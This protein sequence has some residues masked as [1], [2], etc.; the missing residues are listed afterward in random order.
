MKQANT[1][2]SSRQIARITGFFYLLIIMGGLYGSLFVREALIDP[3][4]ELTTLNNIIENE[5]QYRIG[6]LS[7]LVM[8]ISDVMVSVL[9][10]ILLSPVS[11]IA[12]TFAAA[13][14]L[15]QS[16]ILGANLTNLFKPV[17]LISVNSERGAD[18][19]S[20]P[21]HDIMIS[22]QAFEY[23]YLISGVFFA[24]N[25]AFMGYLLYR[26]D[27]FPSFLGVMISMAS[28]GY[29]F[30]CIA[31]FV[32]PSMVEMSEMVLLFTA[33]ISELTLCLWLLIKGVKGA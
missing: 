2:L 23:G 22:L 11:R 26:S 27:L 9:F 7:D 20:V 14:R 21:A 18:T 25:C 19:M 31:S 28:I 1:P 13:F 32:I 4:D 12:A 6:F 15:I 24:V 16:A 3:A 33:I 10:F 8:V 30:N 17:L 5:Q 29:M